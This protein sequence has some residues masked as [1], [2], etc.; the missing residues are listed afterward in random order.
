MHVAS[1]QT[2]FAATWQ[3]LTSQN[4]YALHVARFAASGAVERPDTLIATQQN[5]EL[6]AVAAR[7]DDV[8][9]ASGGTNLTLYH[10]AAGGQVD[11]IASAPLG[12]LSGNSSDLVTT[13]DGFAAL[14]YESGP[15]RE[16]VLHLTPA[17][18]VIDIQPIATKAPMASKLALLGGR[19][20]VASSTASQ[21]EANVYGQF[22]GETTATLVSRAA[23]AQLTPVIASDGERLLAVWSVAH[24]YADFATRG[25]L[26][27]PNGRPLGE[28]FDI[29]PNRL[30][31]GAVAAIFDGHDYLVVR[32]ENLELNEANY[33][34]LV[35]THISRDGVPRG[36]RTIVSRTAS[37]NAVP[38]LATDGTNVLVAWTDGGGSKATFALLTPG[39]LAAPVTIGSAF[40]VSVAWNGATY[41]AV[42]SDHLTIARIGEK[43]KRG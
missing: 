34:G 38:S 35:A 14:A 11:T 36:D 33:E 17:G 42:L 15:G 19:T 3:T 8:F 27:A 20:Y 12:A 5:F 10:I 29:F 28:P 16:F 31:G 13:D 40:S 25:A 41:A 7:G 22:A 21:Q 26:L 18:T 1:T 2:G 4:A 39:G 43:D 23:E 9:V 6:H 32:I 30:A 24:G 37:A